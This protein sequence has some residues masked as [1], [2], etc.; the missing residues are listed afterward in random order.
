MTSPPRKVSNCWVAKLLQ[1]AVYMDCC[2]AR[3]V[4]NVALG[5]RQHIAPARGEADHLQPQVELAQ[6]MRDPGKGRPAP[7]RQDALAVDGSVEQC[8]EPQHPREMR[9]ALRDHSKPVVGSH[10][11]PDRGE[12]PDIVLEPVEQEAMKIDEVAGDMDLHD[13]ALPVS[14]VL[15]PAGEAFDEQG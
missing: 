8:G 7:D 11:E 1:H 6:E 10:G 9:V 3:R 5:E 2:K 4:G 14:Q 12:R 13:L 15:V